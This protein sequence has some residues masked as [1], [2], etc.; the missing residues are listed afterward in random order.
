MTKPIVAM[1]ADEETVDKDFEVPR[2][3]TFSEAF[4]ATENSRVT[5]VQVAAAVALAVGLCQVK[6]F[7][8]QLACGVT[9]FLFQLCLGLF[10]LGSIVSVLLSD[11]MSS[12]F[13]TAAAFHLLASQLSSLLGVSVGKHNGDFKLVLV[14]HII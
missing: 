14:S 7:P 6:I 11:S 3:L 12:G 10:G 13:S 1:Y 8:K 2:E 5:S 4:F 9:L